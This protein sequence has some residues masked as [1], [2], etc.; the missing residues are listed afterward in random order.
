MRALA[1]LLGH[2]AKRYWGLRWRWRLG[3]AAAALLVAMALAV[4]AAQPPSAIVAQLVIAEVPA[5]LPPY[6]RGDWRHWSDG[7]GDCQDTR[8][9]VLLAEAFGPVTFKSESR[10][11]VLGG[12]W[13]GLYTGTGVSDASALD[14]DHMV[15]LQNAHRSGA[16]AWTP[17]KRKAYANDL[18]DPDHLIAVTASAN[19]EKGSRG[20]EEWRPPAVGYW[21]EYAVDWVR[22]KATWSLTATA[23]EWAAL[24]EMLGTCPDDPVVVAPP[25]SP[26]VAPAPASTAIPAVTPAPTDGPTAAP[27]ACGGAVAKISVL[28]KALVP[29]VVTVTGSGD[30]T[31]FYLISVTGNQRFDFP[32]GF[33]LSGSVEVLSAVPQFPDTATQLWWT[34]RNHWNN[35]SD[36]DAELYDCTGARVSFW[37]D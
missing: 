5:G 28:A 18:S 8:H 36:D 2:L 24:Q 25:L 37:D 1:G 9:E 31:G 22:I 6:D 35:R 19:R 3:I 21:C 12:S 7:D 20:P 11:Q 10:C 33:V 27:S 16:W 26:A 17:A 13:L 30:L 34:A 29:E 15:P 14:V 4:P 23:A 32:S